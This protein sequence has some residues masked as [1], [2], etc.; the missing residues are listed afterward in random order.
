[1]IQTLWTEHLQPLWNQLTRLFAS[2]TNL[3]LSWWNNVLSPFLNWLTTVFG[4][5]F[6][7]LFTGA[8]TTVTNV[9][10]V[11]ADA[12]NTALQLLQ[13][14]VGFL[15]NVFAGDWDA[16]WQ[17]IGDSVK[18]M[19]TG[20]R[21]TLRGV[22]NSIIGLVNGML[23]A[24]VEAINAVGRAMNTLSFDVP[25]W[26]PVF[27]GNHIGFQ[28]GTLTAPQI[29]YLAHG[30]RHPSAHAGH[31]GR[32]SRC[33]LRPGDRS[34]PVGHRPG[35][36]RRQRRR[37]GRGAH[38]GGT[39]H[40][41]HPGKRRGDRHRRRGHRPGGA[42]LQQPA[43]NHHG[44]CCPLIRAYSTQY[45]IDGQPMP[46]PDEEAELSFSDLDASD[47]GRTE[48]GVMHRIVVREKVATFGFFLRG[49]GPGGTTPAGKPD[50]RQGGV[51]LRVR[52]Q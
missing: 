37:G 42:P 8:G 39:D 22:V 32:V 29:P 35:G 18:Q 17:C 30:R 23:G 46:E 47:S 24:V 44:R 43:G 21:T 6:V 9:A 7:A 50:G 48:D 40:R 11:I 12:V 27:G 1:M 14:L 49:A 10:G 20:I 2:V 19:G 28:F 41:R 4:P 31:D 15:T 5:L 51:C 52:G 36:V 3:V 45:T 25:D 13:G 34:A 16:A 38:R 26:V 33:G